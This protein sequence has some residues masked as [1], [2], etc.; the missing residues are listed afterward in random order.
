MGTR[1]RAESNAP[2]AAGA[3]VARAASRAS[4]KSIRSNPAAPLWAMAATE[5]LGKAD[6]VLARIIGEVG[7][8]QIAHR[9][10][11][12]QSLVRAIIFQQLAGRAALA[13]YERFAKIVGGRRFPT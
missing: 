10:E 1:L 13:I 6:P 11:R 4:M 2:D 7:L 12:F 9:R 3:R 8:L 5:F